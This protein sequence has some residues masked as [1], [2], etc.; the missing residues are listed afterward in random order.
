MQLSSQ[1]QII[2][3]VQT[4]SQ[5]FDWLFESMGCRKFF[6]DQVIK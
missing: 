5:M 3:D 4:T 2:N 6:H 1:I